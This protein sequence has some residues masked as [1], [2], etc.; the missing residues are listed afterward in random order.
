MVNSAWAWSFRPGHGQFGLGMVGFLNRMLLPCAHPPQGLFF[1]D[2]L[3]LIFRVFVF[4]AFFD[5]FRP[6]RCEIRN[7]ERK[8]D[9]ASRKD[10]KFGL[11]FVKIEFSGGGF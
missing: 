5:R 4:F 8:M 2:F 6:S 10:I 7:P 11:E 3:D 9:A 1:F